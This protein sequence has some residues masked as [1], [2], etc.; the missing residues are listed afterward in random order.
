MRAPDGRSAAAALVA[1]GLARVRLFPGETPCLAD[2]LAAEAGARAARRGLWALADF[3]VRR[4]DDPSLPAQTGLYELVEGQIVSVG[5]GKL[6]VFLDFG[7]DYRRDFTIMVPVAMVDRLP[8]SADAFK[9]RRVR[10][11]GVIEE[12]GGPA[13]RLDS[14]DGIELLDGRTKLLDGR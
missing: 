13:I 1:A 9:G 5:H 10:V 14:P 7:K 4:A 8:L 6:M 12:S 2:L 11:R 3:A